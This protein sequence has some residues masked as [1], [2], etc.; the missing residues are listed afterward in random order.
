MNYLLKMG[1]R[2]VIGQGVRSLSACGF[3]HFFAATFTDQLPPVQLPPPVSIFLS[4]LPTTDVETDAWV[5]QAGHL[6][7]LYF[8]YVGHLTPQRWIFKQCTLYF[9]MLTPFLFC[10]S[11]IKWG[12]WSV[13][14]KKGRDSTFWFTTPVSYHLVAAAGASA[15]V[16]ELLSSGNFPTHNS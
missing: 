3:K 14:A 16:N 15:G 9:S 10:S 1:S 2:M 11:L 13:S 7:M 6:I 8:S 5:Q 4:Q 12:L